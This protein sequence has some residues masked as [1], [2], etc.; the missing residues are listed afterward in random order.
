MGKT[1][2]SN[3][4]KLLDICKSND[5]KSFECDVQVFVFIFGENG[6]GEVLKRKDI[7]TL[8]TEFALFYGDS[9]A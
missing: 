5:Q 2:A 4:V 6:A 7:A 1:Y 3:G 9:R 8:F